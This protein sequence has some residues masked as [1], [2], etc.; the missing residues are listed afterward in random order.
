MI[1]LYFNLYRAVKNHGIFNYGFCFCMDYNSV[2]FFV[3]SCE[4]LKLSW[5]FYEQIYSYD[6]N[7]II[8]LIIYI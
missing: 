2:S 4:L 3:E 6:N 5:I 1:S 8:F 7:K